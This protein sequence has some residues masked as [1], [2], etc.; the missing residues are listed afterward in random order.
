MR[1]ESHGLPVSA[2]TRK[3]MQG[4][5]QR[6]TPPEMAVRRL[7]HRHGYRYRL[8]QRELPG[9][10]DLVFSRLR[11]VIFVHGCFWHRHSCS[12][13]SR[14]VI[15]RREYWR[16]KFERNIARD[17]RKEAAL[18]GLGFQ[19]LVI[20]ECETKERETLSRRIIAFLSTESGGCAR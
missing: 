14:S 13:G 3:I 11:K 18:L 20:W 19:V 6:D 16:E 8:H 12:T 10:P 17:A 2:Q 1:F 15:T 5:K 9:T 4:V 7:V